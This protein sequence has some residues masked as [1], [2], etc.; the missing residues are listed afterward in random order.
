MTSQSDHD[1]NTTVVPR[2]KFATQ[3]MPTIRK[4]A[5]WVGITILGM[6]AVLTLVVG[7]ALALA[8]PKLPDV[9]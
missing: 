3:S 6:V 8:Y 1:S 9:S 2:P 7:L 5:I 4:V